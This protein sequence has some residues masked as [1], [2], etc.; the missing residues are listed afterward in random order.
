MDG[1]C[2]GF[3]FS[4]PIQINWPQLRLNLERMFVSIENSGKKEKQIQ[5]IPSAS[6]I[7]T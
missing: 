5:F 6:E 2:L 7:L 1:H 4:S 3:F